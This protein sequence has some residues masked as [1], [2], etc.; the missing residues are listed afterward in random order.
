M[1][2]NVPKLLRSLTLAGL[3]RRSI[4]VIA[5]TVIATLALGCGSTSGL[6]GESG[7]ISGLSN[8]LP[9][10]ETRKKAGSTVIESDFVFF[11]AVA[12]DEPNAV[13]V[14]EEILKIGGTAADAAVALALTMT[15][16]MPSS[17]SIGGGGICI[18]HDPGQKRTEVIDFIAAPGT[19]GTQTDRPIAVPTLLRGLAALHVRYGHTDLREILAKTEKAAR[20]GHIVSRATARELALSAKPLFQDPNARKIFARPDGKPFEE[21]DHLIQHDLADIYAAL[22]VGGITSFYEG[23]LAARIVKAA[24]DAGGALSL[25]DLNNYV[26]RWRKPVA[27]PYNGQIINFVPSPAGAGIASGLMWNMLT[28]ENRFRGAVGAA[29]LH[30]LL[31]TG[32]RA[33]IARPA[34][35]QSAGTVKAE[36]DFG[37]PENARSLMENFNRDKATPIAKLEPVPALVRENIAGTGFVIVDL[38]GLAV[39]CNLTN[40]NFFGSGRIAPGTG[41]MLAMAPGQAGRNALSLGPIISFDADFQSFRYAIAGSGGAA[42]TTATTSVLATSMQQGITL[43]KALNAP[44]V[45]HSGVP[46]VALLEASVS[47]KYKYDL[48]QRGHKTEVVPALGKVNAVEC[49]LGLDARSENIACFVHADPRGAGMAVEAER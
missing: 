43:K 35:L 48:E 42:A 37:D 47:E 10:S 38:V 12:G 18:V 36:Q 2:F 11:G 30:L 29:R 13:K 26:P 24:R 7:I 34:W 40:F 49:P 16:T 22:R 15:V 33:F 17:I 20:F 27:I 31:E 39:A 46:D 41:I 14:A 23:Q 28:L 19:P 45:H 1:R 8:I 5:L 44:R 4:Q 25:E 3:Y 9:G 32:K 21:G 6:Y